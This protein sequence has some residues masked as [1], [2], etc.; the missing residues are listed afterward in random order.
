[1]ME[2]TVSHSVFVGIL[3]YRGISLSL[4]LF[5]YLFIFSL[6]KMHKGW[7]GQARPVLE[8]GGWSVCCF[9]E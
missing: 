6:T 9:G 8:Q 5:I 1:M 3:L 2:E 4:S 7:P